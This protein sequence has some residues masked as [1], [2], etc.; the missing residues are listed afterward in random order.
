M[1]KA[2]VEL[3]QDRD[4]LL[5]QLQAFAAASGDDPAIRDGGAPRLR[6]ALELVAA[7]S[8]RRRTTSCA[9]SSPTGC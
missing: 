5:L 8:R 3:L 7:R 4:A 2:Y 1:G 9:T 6:R